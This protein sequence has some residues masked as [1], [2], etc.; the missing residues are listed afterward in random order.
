MKH[1]KDLNRGGEATGPNPDYQG[2]PLKRWHTV[3]IVAVE[4]SEFGLIE[5]NEHGVLTVISRRS[6]EAWPH[7]MNP[8][9]GGVN[10]IVPVARVYYVRSDDRGFDL[11]VWQRFASYCRSCALSG[12]HDPMDIDA[13]VAHEGRIVNSPKVTTETITP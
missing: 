10:T 1:E 12:E 6:G 11:S 7:G 8:T 2:P 9:I 5:D 3:E 13:F 4:G